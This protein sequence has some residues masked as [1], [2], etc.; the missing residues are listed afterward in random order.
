MYNIIRR[1]RPPEPGKKGSYQRPPTRTYNATNVPLSRE[2]KQHNAVRREV[3]SEIIREESRQHLDARADAKLDQVL[4]HG[5]VR[6]LG[7]RSNATSEFDLRN[8]RDE[9]RQAKADL[10]AYL[11]AEDTTRRS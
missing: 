7:K 6:N 4:A 9:Y 11:R 2:T 5:D 8:Q 3:M 1:I 10:R